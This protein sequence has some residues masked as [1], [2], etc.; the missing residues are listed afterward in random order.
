M[1][2]SFAILTG[3]T[4]PHLLLIHH[5]WVI[6]DHRWDI[7]CPI[8]LILGAFNMFKSFKVF[9]TV[10][11]SFHQRHFLTDLLR[12]SSSSFPSKSPS[13]VFLSTFFPMPV[14]CVPSLFETRTPVAVFLIYFSFLRHVHIHTRTSTCSCT[15]V[16]NPM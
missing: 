2:G 8:G 4:E 6:H 1:Q 12:I 9:C 14:G 15:Y 5:P 3:C 16:F 13:Q 11:S 10:I 7:C